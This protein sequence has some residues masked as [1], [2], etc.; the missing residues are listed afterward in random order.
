VPR[1]SELIRALQPDGDAEVLREAARG[2]DRRVAEL[3]GVGP[4]EA[5]ARIEEA[6]ARLLDIVAAAD[7][8]PPP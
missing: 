3:L 7:W 2:G 6:K 8:T 5:R 1:L 4:A